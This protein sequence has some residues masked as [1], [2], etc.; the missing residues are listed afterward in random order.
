MSALSFLP[1]F[2]QC[3]RVAGSLALCL[4]L[5][6]LGLNTAAAHPGHHGGGGHYQGGGN[7]NAGIAI[8][9]AA[10]VLMIGTVAAMAASNAPASRSQCLM[11]VG[12]PVTHCHYNRQGFYRCHRHYRQRWVAC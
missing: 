6:C 10:G 7:P 9:V 8:G 5:S 3:R 11:S 2:K 12:R 4:A 1:N